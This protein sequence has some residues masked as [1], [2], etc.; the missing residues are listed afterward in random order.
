MQRIPVCV[1]LVMLFCAVSS[2]LFAL[3]EGYDRFA[4]SIDPLPVFWGVLHLSFHIAVSDVISI[5]FFYTGCFPSDVNEYFS[6]QSFSVG[7]RIYPAGKMHRG[8]YIGP[9]LN[10]NKMNNDM[11]KD[12]VFGYG[13]ELGGMIS[14]GRSFFIDLGAGLVRYNS[15]DA[16]FAILPVV[17]MSFGYKFGRTR[18]AAADAPENI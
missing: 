4:V 16:D 8:F 2:G 10:L 12:V 7:A 5:P 6:M 13:L 14:I 3:E 18:A 15:L 11:S 17:N 9:F 1:F